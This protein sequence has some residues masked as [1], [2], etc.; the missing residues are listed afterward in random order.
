MKGSEG[1]AHEHAHIF[2]GEERD[3]YGFILDAD[4]AGR[5]P[6]GGGLRE[7]HLKQCDILAVMAS[8]CGR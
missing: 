7:S 2:P 5:G 4:K 3:G 1:N 6:G 8:Q